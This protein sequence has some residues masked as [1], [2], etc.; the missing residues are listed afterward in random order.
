MVA[1][2]LEDDEADLAIDLSRENGDVPVAMCR[3]G[4]A[5]SI[6][7]VAPDFRQ[8]V[9]DWIWA[10]DPTHLVSCDVHTF[11]EPEAV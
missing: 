9:Q 5:L 11:N 10:K 2:S 1:V 4:R 8:Q 6:E 3:C 7:D